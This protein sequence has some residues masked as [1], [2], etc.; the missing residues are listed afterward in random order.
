VS[1]LAGDLDAVL[2]RLGAG[3]D[4]HRLLGVVAGSVLRKQLGDAHVA[5]VRR[6]G[7]ERVGHI[8]QLRRRGLDYG[9]IGVAD[10]RDADAGAE[11]D[12]VVAVHVDE[13]G[14]VRPVDVDGK[15]GGDSRWHDG[16]ATLVQLD[17]LRAGNRGHDA[18]L[19]R[20]G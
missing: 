19:L 11:V 13:D 12:E 7:E 20:D 18:S 14:A 9:L 15:R 5:L 1:V 10:G 3:V 8:V 4:E 17:R 2:D 16:E 6:D